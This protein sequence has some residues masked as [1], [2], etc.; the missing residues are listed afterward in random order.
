MDEQHINS[1]QGLF[2]VPH[3]PANAVAWEGS[4]IEIRTSILREKNSIALSIDDCA[5]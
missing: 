4:S 1:K 2:F 3:H 5:T